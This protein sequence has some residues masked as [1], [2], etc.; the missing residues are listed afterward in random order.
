MNINKI[1]VANNQRSNANSNS[2]TGGLGNRC[3]NQL[4]AKTPKEDAK[5]KYKFFFGRGMKEF[6]RHAGLIA[7]AARNGNLEN[8]EEI[9][10]T[11]NKNKCFQVEIKGRI[12]CRSVKLGG[13]K[14]G[15]GKD[16][17]FMTSKTLYFFKWASGLIPGKRAIS[18]FTTANGEKKSSPY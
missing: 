11:Y 14:R 13:A 1:N 8:A 9:I 5:V 18:T 12:R 7:Q 6:Y 3:T 4:N 2:T 16:E 15:Y 17:L 10:K